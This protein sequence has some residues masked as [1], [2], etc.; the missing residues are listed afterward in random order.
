MFTVVF[1]VLS[2]SGASEE[3]GSDKV[4][5]FAVSPSGKL[6]VLTDDSKRLV[7][8]RCEDSWKLISVRYNFSSSVLQ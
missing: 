2:D 7:L 8:F 1:S 4:L 3:T 5:A 6:V